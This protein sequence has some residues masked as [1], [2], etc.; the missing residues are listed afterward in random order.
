MGI[1]KL[2]MDSLLATVDLMFRAIDEGVK[3]PSSLRYSMRDTL[4]CALAMFTMKSRSLLHFETEA[5][6]D[7]MV[8]RNLKRL[9][10]IREVPSDE[11][12]RQRLDQVEPSRLERIF[13]RLFA[14]A[15]RAKLLENT[16]VLG[17]R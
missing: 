16:Q 14:L 9:V 17:G 12:M 7:V 15:Q 8:K 3:R 1:K 6:H 10:S 2:R 11:T 4:H 5:H 13:K